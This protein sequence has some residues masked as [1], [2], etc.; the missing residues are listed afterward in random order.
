[1]VIY[2]LYYM[3]FELQVLILKKFLS[4]TQQYAMYMHAFC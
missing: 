3:H 4:N 2:L 1:M